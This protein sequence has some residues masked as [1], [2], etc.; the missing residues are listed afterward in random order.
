MDKVK[1]TLSE[2][3]D[4]MVVAIEE[5][6]KRS[7]WKILKHIDNDS[8]NKINSERLTILCKLKLVSR[9]IMARNNEEAK[10]K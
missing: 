6:K 9:E 4:Y 2:K 8:L 1:W 7:C 3:L 5:A 10:R